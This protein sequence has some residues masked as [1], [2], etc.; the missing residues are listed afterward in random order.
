M[1]KMIEQLKGSSIN[2]ELPPRYDDYINDAVDV[3]QEAHVVPDDV[4]DAPQVRYII[5]KLHGYE[6]FYSGLYLE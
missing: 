5:P 2:L 1:P 4:A 3:M 6:L